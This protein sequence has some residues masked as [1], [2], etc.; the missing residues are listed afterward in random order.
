MRNF[1]LPANSS[2]SRTI[3]WHGFEIR[4]DAPKLLAGHLSSISLFFLVMNTQRLLGRLAAACLLV[5]S[6]ST[7]AL[8]QTQRDSYGTPRPATR[9]RAGQPMSAPRQA[10]SSQQSPYQQSGSGLSGV[11]FGV[12][13]G[14]NVADVQGDAVQ[15][16][17]DVAG[18]APDG[19]ITR[20]MRPSFHAGVY[21]TIPVTA[22]FA[23]EPGI[24]YSEKGTV[25][26]GKVP[27]PALDFL[28]TQV[29]GTARLSYI[30]VPVLAKVFITDGFYLFAGPQASFLV[31]GKARVEAGA[32]GFTAYQQD[33]DV[34]DQLRT[35]D[36][37]AVGGLGYQL[38]NGLGLSAGYDYGLTSLDKNNRFRARNQVVKASVN[39]SF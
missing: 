18:Y 26:R 33:F 19:A 32:L 10:A 1:S 8:A 11:R 38:N 13:A 21:A 30:D 4:D 25:L 15:A 5:S 6:L 9:S 7:V 28:N 3:F 34:K 36:F 20:N 37:A 16:L 22:S 39:F 2:L 23:I 12:R 14:L 31:S 29:T 24:S 17:L 35:V 27:V